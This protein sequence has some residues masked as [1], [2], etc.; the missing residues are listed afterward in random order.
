MATQL[1]LAEAQFT[2]FGYAKTGVG[3]VELA[4]SMGLKKSEWNKIDH[5]ALGLSDIDIS[6]VENYLD[7]K[8]PVFNP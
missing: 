5:K 7:G 4:A 1:D 2:G 6:E 8:H 3:I